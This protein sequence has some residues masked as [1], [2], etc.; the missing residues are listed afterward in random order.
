MSSNE[1]DTS[2]L[3]K[4]RVDLAKIPDGT[5]DVDALRERVQSDTVVMVTWLQPETIQRIGIPP[6]GICG[7]LES[8][9]TEITMDSFVQNRHFID[10]VHRLNASHP[11]PDLM[12]FAKGSGVAG[13]AVIDQRSP[14]VDAEIP[15]EDIIGH[16]AVENGEVTEYFP[17]KNYKLM[18]DSGIFRLNPWLCRLLPR[19][20]WRWPIRPVSL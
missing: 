12:D 9:S 16:Y 18:T 2:N 19:M 11:D 8:D 3:T 10:I 1:I 20:T 17:N 6:E 14:D 7:I 15:T 5:I 13:V 4:C